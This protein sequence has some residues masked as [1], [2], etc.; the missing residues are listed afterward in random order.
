MS[1]TSQISSSNHR[2]ILDTLEDYARQTGIDLTKNPFTYQFQNCVSP[3]AILDLLEERAMAFKEYRDGNRNLIKWLNPIVQVLHRFV[4]VLGSAT[5]LVRQR[6]SGRLISMFSYRYC[7]STG[8]IATR[9]TCKSSPLWRGCT[10]RGRCFVG[11]LPRHVILEYIR[12]L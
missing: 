6:P 5:S 7:M 10:P 9:K 2:L 11:L 3:R 4:G 1:S 8:A 12:R